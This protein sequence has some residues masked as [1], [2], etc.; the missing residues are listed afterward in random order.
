MHAMMNNPEWKMAMRAYKRTEEL[1]QSGLH[2]RDY[3]NQDTKHLTPERL[4]GPILTTGSI[5]QVLEEMASKCN[6]PSEHVSSGR[7]VSKLTF[8]DMNEKG[9][10]FKTLQSNLLPTIK[11]QIT[12]ML[13]SLDTHNSEEEEPNV[14]LELIVKIL[15]DLDQTI[16]SIVSSAVSLTHGLPLPDEKHDHH[17]KH[18]KNFRCYQ[19]R[20]RVEF[21]IGSR[22]RGLLDHW[23]QLMRCCTVSIIVTD[24]TLARKEASNGQKRIRT[25]TANGRDSIDEAIAWSRKSDWAIV[26]GDWL[27]IAGKLAEFLKD[28]T[29]LAYSLLDSTPDLARLTITTDESDLNVSVVARRKALREGTMDVVRSAMPLLKL[30]RILVKQT[31]KM[32]PKKPIFDLDSKINSKTLTQIDNAFEPMTRALLALVHGLEVLRWTGNNNITSARR[33]KL[34]ALVNDLKPTMKTT[35]TILASHLMPLLSGAD[36]AAPEIDFEAWSLTLEQQWDKVINR[37][38]DLVSS[39]EVAPDEGLEPDD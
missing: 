5:V 32:I 17:L 36:H 10:I 6:F 31:L 2:P 34:R 30:A 15:P 9:E 3:S 33:D 14:D 25:S 8:E 28:L 12:F 1:G 27:S 21:I 7:R 19:L 29:I 35:V 4:T 24:P 20:V 18:L 11:E 23:A 39:F 16:Q 13:T 38:L 26:Q 37:L 22:I